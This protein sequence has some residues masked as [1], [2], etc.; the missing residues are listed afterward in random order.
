[1]GGQQNKSPVK[2]QQL[3]KSAPPDQKC[4]D[5]SKPPAADQK[6]SERSKAPATDSKAVAEKNAA[7]GPTVWRGGV[8]T[9]SDNKKLR[10]QG[11]SSRI[12]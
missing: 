12:G 7:N 5:R 4:S 6:C 3:I 9:G 11:K 2:V 8:I 1:V 10:P